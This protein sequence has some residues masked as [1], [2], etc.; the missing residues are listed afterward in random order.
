M[1]PIV[2]AAMSELIDVGKWQVASGR[3]LPYL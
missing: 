1:R 3:D 2:R